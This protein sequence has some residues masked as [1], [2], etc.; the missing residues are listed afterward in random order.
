M[1]DQEAEEVE[2]IEVPKE[3]HYEYEDF[4]V[5]DICCENETNIQC[6]QFWHD[7]G[8]KGTIDYYVCENCCQE[9]LF[10]NNKYISDGCTG[11]CNTGRPENFFK[12]KLKELA[13]KYT[14]TESTKNKENFLN[15]HN[16]ILFGNCSL[17]R[18]SLPSFI[19]ENQLKEPAAIYSGEYATFIKTHSKEIKVYDIEWIQ[20]VKNLF[21]E[22]REKWEEVTL[23]SFKNM[24]LIRGYFNFALIQESKNTKDML[25]RETPVFLDSI[26]NG[27]EF[28]NIH[29]QKPLN[30]SFE[31]LTPDDF[32]LFCVDLLKSM[33][34]KNVKRI[35][36]TSGDE[37]IDILATEEIKTFDGVE[38]RT[39]SVQCKKV[40][41]NL[42]FDDIG[43]EAIRASAHKVYGLLYILTSD[44]T[45]PTKRQI[46]AY[47]ENPKTSIKIAYFNRHQIENFLL[48]KPELLKKWSS[49]I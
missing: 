14:L 20:E 23:Y 5:C 17:T 11:D 30:I 35:G 4:R 31:G 28:F 15:K 13:V 10:F 37:G 27:I 12:E 49:K 8:R 45:S 36:G 1:G 29:L 42:N 25:E 24:L 21:K 48:Q 43:K 26:L 41:T 6:P 19:A 33:S 34:F 38:D 40:S 44:F 18:D 39:W 32:E 22:M 2:I 47:N 9:A 46:P 16:T 3:E 7:L